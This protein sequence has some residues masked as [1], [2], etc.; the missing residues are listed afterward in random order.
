M[1]HPQAWVKVNAPVDEGVAPI[2]EA[3]SA[4]PQLVT[5]ESCQGD[6]ER[7]MWVC[8][9]YGDTV[10]HPWH[11]LSGFVLG[12]LGPGL[13]SRVGDAVTIQLTVGTFGQVQAEL[14]IQPGAEKMVVRAI[15]ALQRCSP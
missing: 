10:K 8:F 15:R 1:A 5:I 2:I 6:G 4:F 7:P 14:T 12:W 13:M 9:Q 3:L 11:D